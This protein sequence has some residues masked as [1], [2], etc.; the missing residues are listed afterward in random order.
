M[1]IQNFVTPVNINENE[2]ETDQP[3]LTKL[4]K[5]MPHWT[6]EG[7]DKVVYTTVSEAQSG[8]V[9]DYLYKLMKDLHIGESGYPKYVLLGGDQQTYAIMK[10]LKNKYPDQYSWLYP[11]PGDWHIMK[12]A[13]EVLKYV[14]NVAS[15]PALYPLFNDARRKEGRPG[16]RNHVHDELNNE[17]G[18]G[19]PQ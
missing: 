9:S 14:L 10:D 4:E 11:V 17:R 8:Y 13:A 19:I 7:S 12:I 18:R 15:S 1:K 16:T 6:P 5:L 2:I 3:L